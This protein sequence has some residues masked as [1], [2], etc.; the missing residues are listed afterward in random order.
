[1]VGPTI[2]PTIGGYIV[3]SYS[4]PWIFY[5]NVQLGIIDGTL[6]WTDL[7]NASH[8]VQAKTAAFL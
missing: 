2:G 4:W 5:I 3:D 6:D 8:Q 1:M 7:M